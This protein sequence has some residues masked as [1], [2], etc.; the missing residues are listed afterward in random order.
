MTPEE[1]PNDPGTLTTINDLVETIDAGR[2]HAMASRDM[3]G[4][5]RQAEE[6]AARQG[7]GKVKVSV[8]LTLDV[9]HSGDVDVSGEVKIT[10]PRVKHPKARVFVR[11]SAT[12]TL[13]DRDPR[14]G[15]L[16]PVRSATKETGA[17]R[18]A[19]SG[20]S[21]NVRSL[22]PNKKPD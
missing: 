10:A 15:E 18:V 12:G 19:G 7:V 13:A 22:T 16:L 20:N 21:D 11:D 4:A 6:V 3:R 5:I 1:Q 14:Q 9:M 17:V 2:L 8:T